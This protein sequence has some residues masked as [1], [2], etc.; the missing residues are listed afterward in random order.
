MAKKV[1]LSVKVE[2]HQQSVSSRTIYLK[3]I[4]SSQRYESNFESLQASF[5]ESASASASASIPGVGGFSAAAQSAYSEFNSEVRSNAKSSSDYNY[6]ETA[7]ATEFQDGELQIWRTVKTTIIIDGISSTVTKKNFVHS[8]STNDR[9]TTKK[10]HDESIRYLRN[11][12]PGEDSKIRGT[13]YTSETCQPIRKNN[14]IRASCKTAL[15]LASL[16]GG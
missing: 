9:W 6:V 3:R 10:S 7:D 8:A 4:T 12:F 15:V 13:T 14:L 11:E 5:S 16:A 2:H 1:R